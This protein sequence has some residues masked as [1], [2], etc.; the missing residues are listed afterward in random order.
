MRGTGMLESLEERVA[1]LE[2]RVEE[3]SKLGGELRDMMFHLD[4]KVERIREELLAEIRAVD[5]KV[6]RVREELSAE[7]RA[8]DQKVERT[9]EELLT[10]F[11]GLEQRF[12]RYFTWLVGLQFAT[13][14]TIIAFLLRALRSG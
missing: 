4:Q 10:R 14:L 5:Q 3:Q 6:E 7:I 1:Y 11:H 9:R 8:V 12:S 2:G 13:L